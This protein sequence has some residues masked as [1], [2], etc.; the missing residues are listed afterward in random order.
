MDHW[1][2][3]SVATRQTIATE[4]GIATA[5]AAAHLQLPAEEEIATAVP[6][7]H[8]QPSVDLTR[9][10][11]PETHVEFEGSMD[12]GFKYGECPRCGCALHPAV[13][14]SGAHKG[15][16]ILRCNNLDQFDNG[17]R[18][19]WYCTDFQGDPK[20]LP[21]G[22]RQRRPRLLQDLFF[23]FDRV[24]RTT[25]TTRQRKNKCLKKPGATLGGT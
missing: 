17:N 11:A 25:A 19:C 2:R 23:T 5:V 20:P 8:R 14:S 13:P 24:S 1:I 21:K 7:M 4:E 12:K 18:C 15:T 6:L 10:P 9:H 22:I 16:Y 3:H